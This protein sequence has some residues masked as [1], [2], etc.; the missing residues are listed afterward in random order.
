[1]RAWEEPDLP[2]YLNTCLE[3]GFDRSGLERKLIEHM[4]LAVAGGGPDVD[5]DQTGEALWQRTY[6]VR[7]VR[8]GTVYTAAEARA[9]VQLVAEDLRAAGLG[10]GW[11]RGGVMG[12]DLQ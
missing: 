12:A 7:D 1:V 2:L 10:P 6:L 3:E 5:G 8:N 4:I 9:G 11:E